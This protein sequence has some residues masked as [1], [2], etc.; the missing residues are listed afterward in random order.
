MRSCSRSRSG[1]VAA[2]VVG[3]FGDDAL[4]VPD[5]PLV[6]AS[7]GFRVNSGRLGPPRSEYRQ[8]FRPERGLSR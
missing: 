8:Y 2:L 7:S 1:G 5:P 3:V 6:V 4:D